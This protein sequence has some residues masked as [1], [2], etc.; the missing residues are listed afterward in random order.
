MPFSSPHP[1]SFRPLRTS[2]LESDKFLPLVVSSAVPCLLPLHSH[3][4]TR[5]AHFAQLAPSHCILLMQFLIP[6]NTR[7]FMVLA[8]LIYPMWPLLWLVPL[9]FVW[10]QR[11]YI[12]QYKSLYFSFPYPS[13]LPPLRLAS[14]PSFA[15]MTIHVVTTLTNHLFVTN[16]TVPD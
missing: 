9:A 12:F 5:G 11:L 16:Y 6:T 13:S 2:L 4:H 14:S 1:S 3:D 10:I 15:H 8:P 7:F